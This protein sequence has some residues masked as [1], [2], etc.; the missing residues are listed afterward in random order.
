VPNDATDDSSVQNE[1]VQNEARF[2]AGVP[3]DID[4]D[5][6][7]VIV[8]GAG[9][10]G[11]NVADR[12]R[13]AGL[14]T[15]IVESELVGGECSYWRACRARRCCG[16]S[17][18]SSDARAV[19]GSREAVSGG[20]DVA[21]ALAR[22][23]AVVG[24]WKDDGAVGWLDSIGAI[25]VR[26]HGRLAGVKRVDVETPDGTVRRLAAPA[27]GGRCHRHRRAGARPAGSRRGE[28]V[29]QPG[30]DERAQGAGPA[31]D[32][33]RRRGRRGDGHRLA[34]VRFRG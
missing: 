28:A 2:A 12:T 13:A 25:L 16:R 15:A 23:D 8:I 18:R 32:R 11:E 1:S 20:L 17:P 30:G 27:R 19:A 34:G 6:F 9:P 4:V 14:T 31:G 26:G 21:A 29:D 24:N 33:R 7:D 5:V 3:E 10:V 22:R